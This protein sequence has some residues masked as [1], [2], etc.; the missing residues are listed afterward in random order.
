M[1]LVKN[2]SYSY[3]NMDTIEYIFKG[4]GN[5]SET[6]INRVRCVSG[7]VYD[8]SEEAYNT[9]LKYGKAEI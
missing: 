6:I 4:F 9:I 2:T 1:T 3:I 7:E 5:G 8:L